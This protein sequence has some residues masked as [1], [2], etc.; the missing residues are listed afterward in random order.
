MQQFQS[1]VQ[2]M[3][4]LIQTWGKRLTDLTEDQISNC[5]NSQNRSTYCVKVFVAEILVLSVIFIN[6]FEDCV[7]RRIGYDCKRLLN[8]SIK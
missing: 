5:R 3:R 7:L 1:L 8:R 4:S 2:E 6:L